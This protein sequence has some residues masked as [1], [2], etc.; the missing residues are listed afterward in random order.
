[1][2]VAP[3]ATWVKC[4]WWRVP[5]FM[6]LKRKMEILESSSKGTSGQN[7][8]DLRAWHVLSPTLAGPHFD[9]ALGL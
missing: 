8:P 4:G 7:A 5:R 2:V 3:R 6:I 9:L 1:M